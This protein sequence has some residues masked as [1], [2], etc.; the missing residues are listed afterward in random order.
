LTQQEA[1]PG[2]RP[3]KRESSPKGYKSILVGYEGSEN[4][5]RALD[6]AISLSAST[7]ASL[8]IVVAVNTVLMVYGPTAPYYPA[9]YPEQVMKEG[10]SLL[11]DAVKR[12]AGAG[13]KASGSVEDGHPAEVIL[14]LCESKGVDLVVLGRRGISGVERFLMGGVSSTV[15]NHSKCDVMIVR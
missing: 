13:M 9:G 2:P 3:A 7:G 8:R 14:D 5:K 15:V 11:D 10:K 12:A 1:P 4:A 6:R